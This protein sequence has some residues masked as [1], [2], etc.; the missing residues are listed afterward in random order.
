MT[1]ILTE[2]ALVLQFIKIIYTLTSKKT[3]IL[4]D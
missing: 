3:L 1:V 2:G 4:S